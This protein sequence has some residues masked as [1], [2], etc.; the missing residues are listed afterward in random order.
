MSRQKRIIIIY[1]YSAKEYASVQSHEASMLFATCMAAASRLLAPESRVEAIGLQELI[2]C[3]ALHD[4]PGVVHGI[5]HGRWV[6]INHGMITLAVSWTA[7]NNDLIGIANGAEP[8]RDNNAWFSRAQRAQ[9]FH[10]ER[11]VG[12]VERG[13]LGVR[14]E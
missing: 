9:L 14:G 13:C 2:V 12:R 5:I 7:Q 1:R 6:V 4:A 8:M 11:F 3:A 10:D